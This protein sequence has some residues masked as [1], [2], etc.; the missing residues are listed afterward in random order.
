M[1]DHGKIRA[2][3]AMSLATARLAVG[4]DRAI[5]TVQH[6]A[7]SGSAD[8][9][10]HRV[11][12]DVG[13]ESTVQLEAV[14]QISRLHDAPVRAHGEGHCKIRVRLRLASSAPDAVPI[15][16]ALFRR[17]GSESGNHTHG[18]LHATSRLRTTLLRRQRRRLSVGGPGARKRREMWLCGSCW[19]RRGLVAQALPGGRLPGVRPRLPSHHARAAFLTT[20]GTAFTSGGATRRLAGRRQRPASLFDVG[21]H[22]TRRRVNRRCGNNNGAGHPRRG[23]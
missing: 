21:G 7:D 10:V 20:C 19:P 12:L 18:R 8:L 9:L 17:D 1:L 16:I 22:S 2:E 4:E 14:G 23:R 15:R 13:S 5:I 3:H 11:L 6:V